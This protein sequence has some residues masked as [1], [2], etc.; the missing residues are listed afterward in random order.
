MGFFAA[1]GGGRLEVNEYSYLPSIDTAITSSGDSSG[2]HPILTND[3]A[4]IES[5]S[6]STTT[7]NSTLVCSD[8]FYVL[9][10]GN[11]SNSPGVCLPECG[12]WEEFPHN[13]VVAL[14]TTLLVA[15]FMYMI[16][17]TMVLVVSFIRCQ[18]M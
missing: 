16:G 14:D 11:S 5:E 8:G 18:R 15:A 3:N 7:T 1:E 4:T 17:G 6:S 10:T 13:T 2:L 12:E 9:R